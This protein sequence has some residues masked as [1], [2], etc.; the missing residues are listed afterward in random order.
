MKPVA[1]R[2]DMKAFIEL[3]FRL[4]ANEPRWVPP[5][6]LERRIFLNPRQ[7][8]FG[9]HGG[10]FQLFL[11]ERDGRSVGR[12]SAQ[13]DQALNDY[14]DNAWGM[15]GFLELEEDPE[16]L[17]TLLDTAAAWL[18]ERGRDRMVGPM[19][20]QMNDE[21]GVLIEGFE[22]DPMVKQPW[23]PPY[24][25]R[26]CEAAGLEKAVDLYMWNL[27]VSDREK[28]LPVIWELADKLEPEHGIVLRKM[29]RR[30]LRKDLDVFGEI[31]NRAWRRNF[32]FVP[33]SKEDLDAYGQELQLVFDKHWFMVAETK[34][35]E[36]VG[37][38]ITV[39]DVN[40]VLR[41]M[42]GRLLP[43]G[44][45]HFLNKGRTMDRVRVGFLGVKPE[46]QHTG[47]AAGLYAEH[48]NTA[49]HRP[50]TG[51]EMGWILE[52]NDAMNKGMEAMGGTIVKKYRVYERMLPSASATG[53]DSPPS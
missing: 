13:I 31:Y 35:G 26:L 11:A 37:I 23:Q 8:Q 32:G 52:T 9:R 51:G 14:Q 42:N 5:L 18:R 4:H 17:R 28:V 3:P 34:E 33:Y 47:V 19:D 46:Y 25:Q 24:Y 40:K 48:F 45:W 41:K 20:F 49:A 44:W 16:V 43:L 39:P 2:R 38:A 22:L 21:S 7:G 50:Q 12:I 30:R 53:V 6:K 1:S 15:F 29:S 27:E 10:E 36:P